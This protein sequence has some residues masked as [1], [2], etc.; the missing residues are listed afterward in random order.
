MILKENVVFTHRTMKSIS[1]EATK[2]F[3]LKS[4]CRARAELAE[5][6]LKN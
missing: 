4:M 3:I 5:V 2:I 6:G 1:S